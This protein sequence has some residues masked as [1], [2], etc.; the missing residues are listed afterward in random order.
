MRG[1]VKHSPKILTSKEKGTMLV[2][3]FTRNSVV[4]RVFNPQFLFF[5][6]WYLDLLSDALAKE[7]CQ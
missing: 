2:H 3:T 1:I 7:D 6:A 5:A 4:S